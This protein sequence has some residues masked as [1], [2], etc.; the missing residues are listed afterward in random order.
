MQ[1]QLS[2]KQLRIRNISVHNKYKNR[3]EVGGSSSPAGS[4][5]MHGAGQR[6]TLHWYKVLQIA[7]QREP[8]LWYLLYIFKTQMDNNNRVVIYGAS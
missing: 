8:L 6:E 2:K 7:K 1:S 5:R 4:E 3:R